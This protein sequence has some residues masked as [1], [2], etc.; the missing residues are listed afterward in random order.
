[1]LAGESACHI[2]QS[3]KYIALSTVYVA[4]SYCQ[5][6]VGNW[7]SAIGSDGKNFKFPLQDEA[8]KDF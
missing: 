3:S 4:N 5:N 7:A 8:K 6:K 2:V 1:M